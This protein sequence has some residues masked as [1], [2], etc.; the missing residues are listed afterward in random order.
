MYLLGVDFGGGASKATLTD[1][2]G[3]VVA[4]ATAAI[5]IMRPATSTSAPVVMA[6][7][8]AAANTAKVSAAVSM[9]RATSASA[10][11]TKYTLCFAG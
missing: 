3:R 10:A 5:A 9:A 8:N 11:N 6:M 2:E 1:R 7:E 4:T